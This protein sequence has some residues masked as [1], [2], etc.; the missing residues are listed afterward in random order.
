M[1]L[2]G[3]ILDLGVARRVKLRFL[4]FIG[5]HTHKGLNYEHCPICKSMDV[6]LN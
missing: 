6:D 4:P 3:M 5:P 1:V 2:V